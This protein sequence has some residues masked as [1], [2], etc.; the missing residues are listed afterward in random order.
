MLINPKKPIRSV[1]EFIDLIDSRTNSSFS[2]S[3]RTNENSLFRGHTSYKWNLV[4]RIG[5]QGFNFRINEHDEKEMLNTF[6]RFSEPIIKDEIFL[7]FD[8]LAM[9]QHHGM[10]TRLLDWTS[11]P[12]TALWFCVQN[13][14]KSKF[15]SVWVLNYEQ[16]ELID[17]S[18]KRT[19]L[20][21]GDYHRNNPFEIEGIKVFKPRLIAQ[22]IINQNGLFTIHGKS[23][24]KYLTLNKLREF[25]KKLFEIQID[26]KFFKDIRWTLDKL[27]FNKMTQFPDID[28]IASYSE[29]LHTRLTDEMD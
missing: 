19:I 25:D 20:N 12:L 8:F 15:G 11:N 21:P 22:R 3:F 13:P 14:T 24:G 23:K 16:S 9:A 2:S 28:G 7:D 6:K 26:S 17:G 10:A 18:A 27:S 1:G 4:P 5:R 29:W